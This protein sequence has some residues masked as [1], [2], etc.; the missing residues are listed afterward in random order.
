MDKPFALYPGVPGMIFSFYSLS[1]EPL[2]AVAP[3]PHDL[4]CRW[5]VKH[6][7]I[8]WKTGKNYLNPPVKVNLLD[9]LTYSHLINPFTTLH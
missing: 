3:S 6:K 4:S 2:K 8:H 9:I 5:N 1:D 7:H